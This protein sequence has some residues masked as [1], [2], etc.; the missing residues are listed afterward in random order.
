[1]IFVV[2]YIIQIVNAVDYAYQ[3]NE[4]YCNVIDCFHIS[5]VQF[6]GDLLIPL[7]DC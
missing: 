3:E 7:Y 2:P 1:M 6:D 5:I 4:T